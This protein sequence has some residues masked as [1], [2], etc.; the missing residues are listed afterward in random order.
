MRLVVLLPAAAPVEAPKT[1]VKDLLRSD[2]K[3]TAVA[4]PLAVGAMTRDLAATAQLG[5]T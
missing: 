3:V 4:D 1:T 5:S 2:S